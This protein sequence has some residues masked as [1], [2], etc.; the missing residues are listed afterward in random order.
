MTPTAFDL[1]GKVRIAAFEWLSR[2]TKLY[3]DVL[4]RNLLE[5]GFEFEGKIIPL[6]SPQGIFKP[7]ILPEIPLS[8]TTTPSGPYDDSFGKD[9][10]LEYRYRGTDPRHRD[11]EG[12]RMAMLKRAPLI[13][14]HGIVPG[15]YL[16]VWPVFI[17]GD[18]PDQL[19][20]SVA[21]DDVAYSQI[22]SPRREG[23]LLADSAEITRR[24]YITAAVKQRLHQRG[25]RERVLLA[26]REQCSFCRLKHPELLDAAHIIADSEPEGIPS[27][28]NGI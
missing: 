23:L 1:D 16:A 19:S 28:Q 12:L 6:V 11:N 27:V 15:R 8:I 25:F 26:Y 3:S 18:H 17:V 21:A 4:Q 10:L 5:V 9:G 20:F 14:F 22:D 2:Q 13:Y 24:A 7:Q